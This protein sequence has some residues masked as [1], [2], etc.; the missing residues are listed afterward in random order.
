MK[1]NKKQNEN[2][3]KS[4][5]EIIK[6]NPYH[7]RLGRFTSA[8]G[9]SISSGSY[10]TYKISDETAEYLRN[11]TAGKYHAAC[12]ISQ[13][14]MDG[15]GIE[16]YREKALKNGEY[17]D[18]YTNLDTDIY[19]T[20]QIMKSIDEQPITDK[21][22]VRI[23]A[24]DFEYKVG[25]TITWGIRSTSR[26]TDF[27]RK[28]LER[29]DDGLEDKLYSG[30]NDTYKGMTEYRI[31]GK[32][33]ALDISDYSNFD[34]KE[35][36]VQGKFKVISVDKKEYI[37]KPA[38]TIEQ[39]TNENQIP[40]ERFQNFTSKKGNAMVRDTETGITYTKDKFGTL[41]YYNGEVMPKLKYEDIVYYQSLNFKKQTTVTIEQ[42]L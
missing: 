42:I 32:K 9:S 15:K 3:A 20:K 23:E 6:Y 17:T 27:S 16:P 8:G 39:A 2:C 12:E 41:V 4:F 34:Q 1:N 38:K 10:G 7:D 29:S 21:E 37:P 5:S 25:D 18:I 26:D 28:V 11:Y 24:G 33:K 22:L 35:S 14:I 30:Y 13:D 40:K 36:L 31:V 19:Q